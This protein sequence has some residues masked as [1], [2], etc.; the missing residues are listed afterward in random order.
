M[1]EAG[2][3]RYDVPRGAG[4]GVGYR[5][6]KYFVV[7][8][9]KFEGL[10][11]I[12]ML[13]DSEASKPLGP[14]L[15]LY[16]LFAGVILLIVVAQV[17]FLAP[18]VINRPF[19]RLV[20]ATQSVSA[21]EFRAI[22]LKKGF[23][24]EL[25]ALSESF[26]SMILE[27]SRVKSGADKPSPVERSKTLMTHVFAVETRGRLDI[28][29]KAIEKHMAECE[30]EDRE[31]TE[32]AVELKRL[33]ET[34]E[35]FNLLVRHKDGSFRPVIKKIDLAA[36]LKEA[37]E[38]CR[39]FV[40]SREVVLALECHDS[41]SGKDVFCDQKTLKELIAALLRHAVRVTDVGI[42]TL[43]ASLETKEGAEYIEFVLSDTGSGVDPGIIEWTT[44]G[45][46]FPSHRVDLG[47]AREFAELLG[48]SLTIENLQER[49]SL[50]TVLLPNYRPQQEALKQEP[51]AGGRESDEK[52]TMEET[53]KEKA[54]SGPHNSGDGKQG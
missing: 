10:R 6:G 45:G 21:G 4:D 31:M 50:V 28:I 18:R 51:D 15:D 42:V 5:D 23:Y 43:L 20:K 35:A 26:S 11:L 54:G 32:A 52:E 36:M 39:S 16:L 19:R 27:L 9:L 1:T 48:G 49:G 13:D 17:L 34:I 2:K 14:W 7:A 47:I 44:R 3:I 41:I 8:P 24:G 38:E 46:V 25:K 29:K 12:A 53:D 22:N 37:E 33:S 40:G 30:G